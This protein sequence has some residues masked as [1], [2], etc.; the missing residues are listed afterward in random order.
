MCALQELPGGREVAALAGASAGGVEVLG[1]APREHGLDLAS[2][3]API[4]D[5]LLE[6]PAGD[7]VELG[8][9]ARVFF[10]PAGEAL[11]QLGSR[12]LR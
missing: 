6:V 2:E 8:E 12:R 11:V 1:G 10:Q 7:L 5:R 4:A 3:L 9:L